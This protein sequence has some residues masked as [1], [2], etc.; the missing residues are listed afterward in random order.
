MEDNN[1]L[2]TLGKNKLPR[3][4]YG[5][6][7]RLAVVGANSFLL[8]F[9][10]YFAS[11]FLSIIVP[12]IAGPPGI[13]VGI[14]SFLAGFGLVGY[15]SHLTR[16]GSDYSWKS[17]LGF[18]GMGAT[19]MFVP[20]AYLF[21]AVGVTLLANVF[22][23]LGI[24][25]LTVTLLYLAAAVVFGIFETGRSLWKWVTGITGRRGKVAET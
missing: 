1:V 15:L 20:A 17:A 22:G 18:F 7:R 9:S 10:I 12:T 13:L 19:L 25:G 5:R 4:A 3:G 6:S 11:S 23:W 21:S 14:A 2:T 24:A 16:F 8:G